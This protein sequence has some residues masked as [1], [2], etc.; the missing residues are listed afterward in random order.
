MELIRKVSFFIIQL[1]K[2]PDCLDDT[3]TTS[4]AYTPKGTDYM[5]YISAFEDSDKFMLAV[6]KEIKIL[7]SKKGNVIETLTHP[8][9]VTQCFAF[10]DDT[11]IISTWRDA[12]V[13]VWE[14]D[15]D[16]KYS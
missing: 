4:L 15:E 14:L 16:G 9:Q 2:T 8:K 7:G 13:R 1:S 11:N 6:N 5:N 3:I 12:M 10:N